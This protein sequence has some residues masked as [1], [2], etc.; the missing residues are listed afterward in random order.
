MKTLARQ[1]TLLDG[2]DLLATPARRTDPATSHIAAAEIE[3]KLNTLQARFVQ[4]VRVLGGATASE[5]AKR[6]VQECGG[7][8]ETA[9]K[10]ARECCELGY[11]R[12]AGTRRCR[13]TGKVAQFYEVTE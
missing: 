6:V 11:V 9:R 13:V 10:R 4:A 7:S 2:S 3:P 1:L 12:I 5:A 8:A